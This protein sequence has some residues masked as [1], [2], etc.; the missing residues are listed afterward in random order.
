MGL[1]SRSGGGR[2]GATGVRLPA[3][4]A[5]ILDH[6]GRWEFDPQQRPSTAANRLRARRGHPDYLAMLDGSIDFLR[7]AGYST[8]YLSGIE[9][10]RW[11]ETRGASESW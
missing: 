9:M 1:F 11:N 7:S 6:Y 3:G 4:F 5:Q 8:A 2:S 10:A